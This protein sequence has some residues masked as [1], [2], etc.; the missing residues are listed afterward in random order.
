MVPA[1]AVRIDNSGSPEAGAER[2]ISALRGF[3]AG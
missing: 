2:V 1:G 3:A